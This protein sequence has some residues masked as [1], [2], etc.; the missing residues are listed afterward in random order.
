MPRQK[1]LLNQCCC[2]LIYCHGQIL[3]VLTVSKPLFLFL[4]LEK[5]ATSRRVVIS[6][7][8][9][10]TCCHLFL[11][12]GYGGNGVDTALSPP[13]HKKTINFWIKIL[14]EK[15]KVKYMKMVVTVATIFENGVP[16]RFFG[17]ATSNV[18]PP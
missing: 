4:R 6:S 10:A 2:H 16:L 13:G 12:G 7:P 15:K 1:S 17:V 3:L 14:C 5:V 9:V 11:L 8:T 18:L